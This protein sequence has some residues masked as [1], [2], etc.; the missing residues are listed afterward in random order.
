MNRE[1]SD[2]FSHRD[3]VFQSNLRHCCLF[4]ISDDTTPCVQTCKKV[5]AVIG[6]LCYTDKFPYIIKQKNIFSP[7]PL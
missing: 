3:V 5:F 4:E 7:I 6:M 2:L 1:R